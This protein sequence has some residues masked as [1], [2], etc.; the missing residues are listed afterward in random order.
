MTKDKE[1]FMLIFTLIYFSPLM[2]LMIILMFGFRV[3]E[4]NDEDGP[5]D[6]IG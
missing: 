5:H 4:H 6:E 3:E 2:I 1:E